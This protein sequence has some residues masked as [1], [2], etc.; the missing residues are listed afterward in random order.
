ML[1]EATERPSV[2]AGAPQTGVQLLEGPHGEPAP[3][4][5]LEEYSE[6]TPTDTPGDALGTMEETNCTT[7]P[8]YPTAHMQKC[9]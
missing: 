5:E 2:A 6:E 7:R 3:E 1:L 4:D 9:L 8:M